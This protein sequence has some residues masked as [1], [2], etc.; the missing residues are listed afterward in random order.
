[1][2]LSKNYGI[3]NG[4]VVDNQLLTETFTAFLEEIN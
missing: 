4:E 2:W 1:M 3:K